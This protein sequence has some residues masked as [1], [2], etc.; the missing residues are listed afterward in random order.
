MKTT[1][2][3]QQSFKYNRK[4]KLKIYFNFEN[5]RT[6]IWNV[7]NDNVILSVVNICINMNLIK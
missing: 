7:E 1:L 3:Q 2:Q 5:Y 4:H 6:L